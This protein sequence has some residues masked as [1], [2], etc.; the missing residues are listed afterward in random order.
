MLKKTSYTG[1]GSPGVPV[2]K[3]SS[4][5]PIK[6]GVI[7]AEDSPVTIAAE[8]ENISRVQPKNVSLFGSSLV[9]KGEL[10]ADEEII[11][12]GVVEG[13]IAHHKKNVTIG[14]QGRVNALIHARSVTIQGRVDGDIHG[15]EIVVMTEGA[16]VNGNI[17]C[18]RIMMED[19]AL[20]NGSIQMS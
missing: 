12:Q 9:F 3:K 2:S 4:A 20:F 1:S 16:E 19:G 7:E 8:Y 18:P 6:A 5:T 15:D 10:S 13:T 14:K 11:I 17:Y